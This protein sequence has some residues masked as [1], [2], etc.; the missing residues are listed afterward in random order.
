MLKVLLSIPVKKLHVHF[1]CPSMGFL[2]DLQE[3]F[4]G[5]RYCY[6]YGRFWEQ[7]HERYDPYRCEA[8]SLAQGLV[9]K[10][11]NKCLGSINNQGIPP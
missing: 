4:V 1:H 8:H 3:T 10:Q 7:R 9:T 6:S 5:Y 2:L 11:W